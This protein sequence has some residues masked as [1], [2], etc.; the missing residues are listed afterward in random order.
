MPQAMPEESCSQA[1]VQAHPPHA[2][3]MWARLRI[4]LRLQSKGLC[5]E[6]SKLKLQKLLLT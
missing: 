6:K 5:G 1:Y 2:L 4:I 3:G